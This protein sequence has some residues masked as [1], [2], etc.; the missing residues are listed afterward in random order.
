MLIV[1]VAALVMAASLGWFAYGLLRDERRRADA[2]VALLASALEGDDSL[3]SDP[4]ARAGHVGFVA[5]RAARPSP[6]VPVAAPA[7]VV[8]NAP[9]VPELVFLEDE[10]TSGQDFVSERADWMRAASAPA[11][12]AAMSSTSAAATDAVAEP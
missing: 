5:A 11:T 4:P 9:A 6:P 8:P 2:R 1:T 10:L 12:R 7:T 3:G